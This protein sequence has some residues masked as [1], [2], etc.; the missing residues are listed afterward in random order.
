MPAVV[1]RLEEYRLPE[2]VVA[3]V[4]GDADMSHTAAAG[5]GFPGWFAHA[6]RPAH[7]RPP[8]P[9]LVTERAG[10]RLVL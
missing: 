1:R 4:A 5:G 8:G 7:L 9:Q 6:R 2:L 3:A 10:F